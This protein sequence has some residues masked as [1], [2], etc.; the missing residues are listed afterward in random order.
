MEDVYKELFKIWA[1]GKDAD[2]SGVRSN[3]LLSR[4]LAILE[5]IIDPNECDYDHHGYCQEHGWF[6]PDIPC[7][8]KRAKELLTEFAEIKLAG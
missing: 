7:P 6:D 2:L 3:D 8:H 4:F 5:D 1:K